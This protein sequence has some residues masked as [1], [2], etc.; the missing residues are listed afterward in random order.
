MSTV[1]LPEIEVYILSSDSWRSLRIEF[2]TNVMVNDYNFRLTI[3][4]VSGALHW[5]AHMKEGEEKQGIDIILAFDANTEKFRKLAALPH[6]FIKTNPCDRYLTS[7]KR[8][9]AFI[10]FGSSE[11]P[12]SP[13][14]IWVMKEYGVVES[15]IKLSFIPFERAARCI[16]FTEYGSL[17]TWSSNDQVENQGSKFVSF[18]AETLHKKDLDIQYTSF[19]ATFVESLVLLDEAN[20]ICY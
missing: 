4:L 1:S 16:A 11:Q 7:F 10:T 19:A 14:S 8:K 13:C 6:V 20:V 9:L 18:D 17:L 3:P 2:A 5:F 15:W 12:G